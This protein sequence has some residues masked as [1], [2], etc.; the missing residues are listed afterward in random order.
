VSQLL[1]I[2]TAPS[3]MDSAHLDELI[4][5]EDTYWWHVAKR[6]LV[7]E[8]VHKQF[9]PP[10]R[11]VEGG[12]GS[13]R[14]LL[15]FEQMGYHVTG[16]DV[17]SDAVEHAKGRGIEDVDVLDLQTDWGLPADSVH[18]VLLLD[19]LEH[20]ADP[21]AALRRAA[22]V[23]DPQGGVIVTV[24]AYPFL[25]SDWD[26]KLGHYRRYTKD[27]LRQQADRA[28]LRVDWFTHW[29]AFT[30][31]PAI[32]VRTF[33]RLFPRRNG[34]EFPRVSP[35]VNRLLV[36]FARMERWLLQRTGVPFGLSLVGVLKK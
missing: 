20:I 2:E 32:V 22:D 34:T 29:N 6:E 31:P 14:N 24:P 26:H 12:I 25:M 15:A 33:E 18:V 30:L 1:E 10:G 11:L 17:M 23:L 19:V 13:A 27:M 8:I 36:R 9:P 4:A 5:L 35:T 7:T 21:V 3:P 28:G 16:F